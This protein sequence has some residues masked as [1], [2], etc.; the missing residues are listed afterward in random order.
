MNK[1]EK[2]LDQLDSLGL[3]FALKKQK[4]ISIKLSKN[5]LKIDG[6]HLDNNN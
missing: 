3:I 6:D 5:N 1:N 2:A 4:V